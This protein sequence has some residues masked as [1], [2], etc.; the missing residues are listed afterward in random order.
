MWFLDTAPSCLPSGW[1]AVISGF[2][3]LPFQASMGLLNSCLALFF[4]PLLFFIEEHSPVVSSSRCYSSKGS[5]DSSLCHAS[6][7]SHTVP[8]IPHTC[9]QLLEISLPPSWKLSFFSLLFWRD[10]SLYL[11]YS[12]SMYSV[13]LA[14]VSSIASWD[15]MSEKHSFESLHF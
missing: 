1:T 7:S 2:P 15:H 11:M 12:S 5:Q 10:F 3:L 6:L 13:S 4:S 8:F 9:A 14:R